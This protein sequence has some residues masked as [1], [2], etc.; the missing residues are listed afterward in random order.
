ML[1]N[2]DFAAQRYNLGN[3]AAA[4]GKGDE[5]ESYYQQ[6]IAIDNQF[7][8]A[9]VHLAMRYNS[10]GENNKAEQLFREV[11]RDNP[12]L[13]EVSYSLGLLLAEMNNL[14]EAAIYLGQ[15]ADGMPVYSRA[16]YNQALAL[17]KLGRIEEGERALLQALE[18]DSQNRQ[19]FTTI[20]NLYLGMNQKK[21]AIQLA[22]KILAQHPEHAEAQE[23]MQLLNPAP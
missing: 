1:Y 7:F 20:I 10:A 17:L 16:R 22:E 6:A 11:V 23:I 18:V 15:A 5:A 9:K 19:Y 2:A 21:K 12:N 14:S 13:Y 3:L 4:L 8:P